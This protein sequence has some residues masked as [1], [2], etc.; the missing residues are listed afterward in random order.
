MDAHRLPRQYTA[1]GHVHYY[2]DFVAIV[3]H[4]RGMDTR[5][6]VPPLTIEELQSIKALVTESGYAKAAQ[7]LGVSY[8]VLM[9][10]IGEVGGTGLRDGSVLMVRLGLAGN[11]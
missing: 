11:P 5:H 9:R 6:R 7:R 3:C 8:Q 10:A 1:L 2:I 4:R